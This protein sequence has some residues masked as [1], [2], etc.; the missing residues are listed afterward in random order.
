MHENYSTFKATFL[1]LLFFPWRLKSNSVG[2]EGFIHFLYLV[3]TCSFA[4]FIF[5]PLVLSVVLHEV[6]LKRARDDRESSL[7]WR[8]FKMILK[9]LRTRTH[10]KVRLFAMRFL[11][12]GMFTS[13]IK[14]QT[15]VC[16]SI[17]L[18]PFMVFQT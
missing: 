10:P 16:C 6:K 7:A 2:G 1:T 11:L 4:L 12:H 14:K 13:A 5:K 15:S 18:I 8:W 9:R 17:S 3:Y